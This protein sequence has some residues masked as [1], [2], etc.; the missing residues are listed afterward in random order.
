MLVRQSRLLASS[1]LVRDPVSEEVDGANECNSKT[2]SGLHAYT[3]TQLH[4]HTQT[5]QRQRHTQGRVT[6]AFGSINGRIVKFEANLN[7]QETKQN[8]NQWN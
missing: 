3:H 1:R 8:K 2:S 7:K 5:T 4:R 6:P